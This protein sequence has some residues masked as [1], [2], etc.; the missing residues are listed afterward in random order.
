MHGTG[1]MLNAFMLYNY[2]LSEFRRSRIKKK[3]DFLNYYSILLITIKENQ[4]WI[5][6]QKSLRTIDNLL[7]NLVFCDVLFY[8]HR[9][10]SKFH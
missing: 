10:K 4:K 6:L 9:R 8:E 2:L 5:M 1:Y 7:N 3:Y